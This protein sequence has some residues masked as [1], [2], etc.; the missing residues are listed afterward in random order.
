MNE[1]LPKLYLNK[2]RVSKK[3]GKT[4]LF[5]KHQLDGQTFKLQLNE[6]V[7]PEEW[8]QTLQRVDGDSTLT[9]KLLLKR[10][11][12]K[13]R[14][15]IAKEENASVSEIQQLFQESLNQKLKNKATKIKKSY[16]FYELLDRY[17]EQYQKT[18][19]KDH[20]KK[21]KTVRKTLEGIF[22]NL[23]YSEMR[24]E[25]FDKYRE[26]LE[27]RGLSNNYIKDQFKIIKRACKY[28]RALGI[29]I[30]VD[31]DDFKVVPYK[32]T[33]IW[34]NK[35]ELEALE[36]VECN[37]E[38]QKLKDCF[39]FRCYT[40]LRHSDMKSVNI[41]GLDGRQ[42]TFHIR[43][44]RKPHTITLGDKSFALLKKYKSFPIT[45]VQNENKKIKILCQRAKI[46]T[47]I[48]VYRMSGSK[49]IT[50]QFPK[51]KKI[52]GHTARRTFAKLA[53]EKG[54]SL[55]KLSRFIGHSSIEITQNYIGESME[56]QEGI[57]V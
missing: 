4:P 26:E 19:S 11:A 45:S 37:N 13:L 49:L 14:Y 30:P 50:E 21:F 33:I 8:N 18:F 42:L 44:Q 35:L 47:T 16:T 57:A 51:Y 2:Q 52:T 3:T 36:K 15:L 41:F 23:K 39:L 25:L 54:I 40:G 43:K 6:K 56:E 48:E 20:L 34:L 9:Q 17:V 32:G 7:K 29:N 31:I 10:E 22:P 46:N 55:L 1:N 24:T 38:E 28:G 12:W 27:D 5:F 53:Y